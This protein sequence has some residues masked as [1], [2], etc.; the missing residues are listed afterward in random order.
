MLRSHW[1]QGRGRVASGVVSGPISARGRG[2]AGVGAN[3]RG[4]AAPGLSR[5]GRA[6]ALRAAGTGA[7]CGYRA[8]VAVAGL[9]SALDSE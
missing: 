2:M 9:W 5:G 8:R 7:A 3:G 6:A 4:A 1:R